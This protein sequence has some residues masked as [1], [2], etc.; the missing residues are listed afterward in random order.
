VNPFPPQQGDPLRL[1]RTL[2]NALLKAY[3]LEAVILFGSLGR[4][5]GDE[6]SDVD[7]LL[8][9]VTGRDAD[10]LAKEM[11]GYLAH[12]MQDI[13]I[14]IRS[15]G[16]YHRQ[17]DIPGTLVYAAEKEGRSLFDSLKWRKRD[18]PV[19]SY[20][21]RKQEVIDR[22]YIGSSYDFLA[23]ARTSL[24]E[25]QFFRSRD[26]LRFAVV[27]AVK[28]I[29]V[30]HDIHPPRDL[31]LVRLYKGVSALEPEMAQ[32]DPWIAELN[33]YTPEM[34]GHDKTRE[35]TECIAKT[36][37]WIKRVIE[38]YQYPQE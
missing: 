2:K 15:P 9:M 31:D 6:F 8:V 19:E 16:E 25:G 1:V 38:K 10:D 24:E 11:T 35:M 5:D 7:L 27:R 14:I 13:H 28:G 21:T 30:R 22:E 37:E 23:K 17:C 26:F 20:E 29:F 33:S 34:D 12:L 3:E 36:E 4:G 32:D 18:L